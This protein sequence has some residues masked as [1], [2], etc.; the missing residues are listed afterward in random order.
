VTTLAAAPDA[1]AMTTYA[2]RPRAF[3]HEIAYRLEPQHLVVDSGRK[4]DRI[5]YA[6]IVQAR[7]TYVPNNFIWNSYRTKLTLTDGRTLKFGNFSFRSYVQVQNHDE[8]YR[9]FVTTLL[10]RAKQANPRLLC[11]AGRP[12]LLWWLTLAAGGGMV[13]G[14]SGAMILALQQGAWSAVGL[15]ALILLPFATLL[16]Q[17]IIRNRPRLF[18]P[19]RPPEAVMPAGR[20]TTEKPEGA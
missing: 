18:E 9:A 7:L 12:R 20:K 13:L 19:P 1:S 8:A 17:M 5:P 3:G 6:R 14:L 4:T 2:H 10:A 15:T 16:T 11:V